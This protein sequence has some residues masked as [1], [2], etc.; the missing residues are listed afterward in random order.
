M[1]HRLYVFLCLSSKIYI[2]KII[3][4]IVTEISYLGW[5]YRCLSSHLYPKDYVYL[6]NNLWQHMAYMRFHGGCEWGA[7]DL[8]L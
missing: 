5:G 7:E 8:V 2:K 6:R 4:T 1:I 3:K